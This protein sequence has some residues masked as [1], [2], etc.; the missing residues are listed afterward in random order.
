MRECNDDAN[1]DGRPC[2]SLYALVSALLAPGGTPPAQAAADASV[3]GTM[4]R[5]DAGAAG[6]PAAAGAL[7]FFAI[8]FGHGTSDSR[9]FWIGVGALLATAVLIVWRP[10][11]VGRHAAAF[12]VLLGAFVLW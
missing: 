2:A 1:S 8:F 11:P 5:E 6:L 10:R 9:V 7:L 12:L 3:A 4:P